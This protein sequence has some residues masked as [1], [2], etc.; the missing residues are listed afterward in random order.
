[1]LRAAGDRGNSRS[2]EADAAEEVRVGADT[3]SLFRIRVRLKQWG[4]TRLGGVFAASALLAHS[5][6]RSLD[7]GTAFQVFIGPRVR[8][9]VLEPVRMW[10]LASVHDFIEVR[11]VV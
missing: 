4:P 2:D 7:L 11:C 1:M 6:L 8:F 9:G 10:V 3:S 5:G